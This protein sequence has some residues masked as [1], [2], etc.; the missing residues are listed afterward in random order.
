MAG[1]YSAGHLILARISKLGSEIFANEGAP[2][3]TD[4]ISLVNYSHDHP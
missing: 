3:Y 4:I 1:A 2:V